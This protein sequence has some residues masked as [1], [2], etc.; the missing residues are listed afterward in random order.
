MPLYS[1][2]IVTASPT[3]LRTF[4]SISEINTVF[5]NNFQQDVYNKPV[6]LRWM[7]LSILN[8][9]FL[10]S[11][12]QN[13]PLDLNYFFYLTYFIALDKGVTKCEERCHSNVKKRQQSEKEDVCS[14]QSCFWFLSYD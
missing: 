11:Y 7:F 5:E 9:S 4:V 1:A 8:G 10:K 12:L 3:T 14:F 6:F 13:M 2:F